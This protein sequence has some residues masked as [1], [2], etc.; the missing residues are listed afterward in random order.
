MLS[1]KR[2]W[3]KVIAG[4]YEQM[5]SKIPGYSKQFLYHIH[6]ETGKQFSLTTENGT[7]YAAFLPLNNAIINE[8]EYK[9]GEFLMFDKDEGTIEINNISMSP[10]DIILFGGKPYTEPIVAQ[11]PFVM[12]TQAEIAQAYRDFHLGKYGT[13][14][15]DRITSNIK[16]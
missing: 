15:Y 5:V 8:S 9:K 4:E 12:N 16:E 6:L 13:I 14:S 1:D 7:E 10:T 2:G 3:I 11:G